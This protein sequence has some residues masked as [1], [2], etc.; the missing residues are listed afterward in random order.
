MSEPF[1][2]SA[3][4]KT[5]IRLR[6]L[7]KRE[8]GFHEI[9][10]RMAPL[11]LADHLTLQWTSDDRVELSCSD[12]SLP[13][14][15]DNLVVKA[16]R[17]L[18]RRVSRRLS[19]RIHL[20]KHIPHGAGLGGGSS[21]AAS[22]LTALN[23]MGS[24]GLSRNELIEMAAEIGSDVPFFIHRRAC[25]CRGRGEILEPLET[26]PPRLPVFLAKPNFGISAAWAYRN[27][28]SSSDYPDAPDFVQSCSW[29]EVVNDLERPVFEKYLVL[30]DLKHW[31]LRREEVH[32][33]ILSGSGSA[34]LVILRRNDLGSV[35]RDKIHAHYGENWWTWTG[36]TA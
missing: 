35:L 16:V 15:E 5:N 36:Y 17:A 32:A 27:Y 30:A 25:D 29:G 9:D 34:M 3:P 18:E 19:V 14:G 26:S 23:R 8:D 20:E 21:D 4:A 6:V 1:A 22:T 12:P 11:T 33:A 24:F 28:A 31:L 2:I 7:G 13:T 10:T